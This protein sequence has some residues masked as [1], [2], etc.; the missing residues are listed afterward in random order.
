M[1]LDAAGVKIQL[2]KGFRGTWKMDPQKMISLSVI[3]L[4]FED[5]PWKRHEWFRKYGV[6]IT[7]QS[8]GSHSSD[9]FKG[10]QNKIHGS[11]LYPWLLTGLVET[12]SLQIK[13]KINLNPNLE[14]NHRSTWLTPLVSHHKFDPG[15]IFLCCCSSLNAEISTRYVP[16][17]QYGSPNICVRFLFL[18]GSPFTNFCNH[19]FGECQ[20]K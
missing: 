18:R 6:P 12:C 5:N 3:G 10:D 8:H 15:R 9:G 19:L 14:M 13:A 17:N 7:S 4:K 16:K 1:L 20:W 2:C 11:Q